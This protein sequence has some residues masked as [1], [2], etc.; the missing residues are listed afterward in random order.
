MANWIRYYVFL[1][2][3]PSLEPRASMRLLFWRRPLLARAK[4]NTEF[5]SF[6]TCWLDGQC[7]HG[8]FLWLKNVEAM[9]KIWHADLTSDKYS[10]SFRGDD[11]SFDRNQFFSG[12][13]ASAR[14]HESAW[15][16]MSESFFSVWKKVTESHMLHDIVLHILF[17]EG[18]WCAICLIF[19]L[20]SGV[21]KMLRLHRPRFVM[22]RASFK[23]ERTDCTASIFIVK[24]HVLQRF[25]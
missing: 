6:C 14:L 25:W 22:H 18:G 2:V 5:Q 8:C 21:S 15:V 17:V 16:N 24:S 1:Q 19:T 3:T 13:I 9:L 4:R 11:D 12:Y 10:T 7:A 20:F 23:V